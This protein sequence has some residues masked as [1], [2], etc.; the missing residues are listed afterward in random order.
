M[1]YLIALMFLLVT[2]NSFGQI[3]YSNDSLFTI[4]I[5]NL[6]TKFEALEKK[7]ITNEAID[8]KTYNSISNQISAASLSI[9]I[10]GI[11]F[12][13]VA[14]GIGIYVTY[15]ERK[16]IKIGEENKELLE[17]NKK[18]KTDVQEINRLIQKDIYGLFIKIK[19]EETSHILD[20]L[21]K[22]PKD[23][24]NLSTQLFSR[25]LER[26]DFEK[27]KFAFNKLNQDDYAYKNTYLILF[28][29]HFAD[30]AISDFNTKKSMFEYMPNAISC[31][32]DN[33]IL[34][35]TT[36]LFTLFVDKG[37]INFK[38]EI[39]KYFEGVG[40]SIYK[41]HKPLY[42]L[43]FNKLRQRDAQFLVYEILEP[44]EELKTI[45]IEY[46]QFLL[47]SFSAVEQTESEKKLI[48]EIEALKL[49]KEI[50]SNIQIELDL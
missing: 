42:E 33:D 30:L 12:G 37:I 40:H 14:I 5:E 32:F 38:R 20:R 4:Q 8:S 41:N 36:D 26:G 39:N 49:E 25:E 9:T 13:L 21:Q 10:F 43:I 31:S 7:S 17:Q 16:I 44:K 28:F 50:Q 19:R 47:N 35:S 34:K 46:G 2:L 29:Q 15:V 11:I 22:I 1:K 18:I 48:S 23:I 24:S 3:K 6:K 45:K 27:L